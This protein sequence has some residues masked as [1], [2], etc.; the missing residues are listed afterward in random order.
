MWFFKKRKLKTQKDLVFKA[1]ES[2]LLYDREQWTTGEHWMEHKSGLKMWIANKDYGIHFQGAGVNITSC[3]IP[4]EWKKRF[5]EAKKNSVSQLRKLL[6]AVDT[7]TAAEKH[8]K[9]L[10]F[11][12][13]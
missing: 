9:L 8:Q 6:D 12:R 11:T 3:E 4:D 1:V 7:R 5:F 2:S 13:L 10:N